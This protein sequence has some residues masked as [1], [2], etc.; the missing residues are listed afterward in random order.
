MIQ[1]S[2]SPRAILPDNAKRFVLP[3]AGLDNCGSLEFCRLYAFNVSET[4]T[5]ALAIRQ[6]LRSY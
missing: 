1:L 5:P 6:Q 3:H 2:A 4:N